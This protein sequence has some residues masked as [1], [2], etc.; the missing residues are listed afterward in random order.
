MSDTPDERDDHSGIVWEAHW[1][2]ATR[3]LINGLGLGM[4]VNAMLR[5]PT[6]QHIDVVEIDPDV[7]ALVK[8]HYDRVA[9]ECGVELAI[10]E[11]DAYTIQW[12]KGTWWDVAW[13]DIWLAIDTG[14]LPEMARLHR[15]YGRRVRSQGSWRK[16]YLQMMRE[17]ER[18][19]GW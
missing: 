18:R 13:H 7:I 9:A 19:A 5:I 1:A 14:N 16:G 10:H 6:M 2:H 3:V 17:R 8:P 15:K 11:A 4:V 12:P